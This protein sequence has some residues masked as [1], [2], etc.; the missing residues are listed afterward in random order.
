MF[1]RRRGDVELSAVPI[2][3][4]EREPLWNTDVR[5]PMMMFALLL[6]M[7]SLQS[8]G[9]VIVAH[10]DK[11]PAQL[12]TWIANP[13]GIQELSTRSNPD[14]DLGEVGRFGVY[15]EGG[16]KPVVSRP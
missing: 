14:F 4:L 16:S 2:A 12:A 6:T 11:L 5:F 1:R 13:S 7:L 15:R 10:E 9:E 8:L 3:A